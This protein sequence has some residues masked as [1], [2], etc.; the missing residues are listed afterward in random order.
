MGLRPSFV[1]SDLVQEEESV[2]SDSSRII[3]P[4]GFFK[5]TDFDFEARV[6]LHL[7]TVEDSL[8]ELISGVSQ[9]RNPGGASAFVD[10]P[11]GIGKSFLI[12]EI[13]GSA[14]DG[15]PLAD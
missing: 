1:G 11:A 2:V 5:D 15:G 13:L 7:R 9:Q 14:G 8:R 3:P 10:S 4:G 12:R 6:A